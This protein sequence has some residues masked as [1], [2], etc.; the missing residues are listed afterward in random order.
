[1]QRGGGAGGGGSS[2]REVQERPP[3][4]HL[5]KGRRWSLGLAVW[6]MDLKEGAGG[7]RGGPL[8][9]LGPPPPPGTERGPREPALQRDRPGKHR[10]PGAESLRLPEKGLEPSPLL[11]AAPAAIWGSEGHPLPRET[12]CGGLGVDDPILSTRLCKPV[13]VSTVSRETLKPDGILM[14]E[15]AHY[16]EKTSTQT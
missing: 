6:M 2:L 14:Q 16:K 10:Y 8:Q 9:R 15:S 11:L 13:N 4:I 3:L 1:M 12:G 5:E 7:G